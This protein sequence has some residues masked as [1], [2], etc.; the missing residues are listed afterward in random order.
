M[1][2]IFT[3][4]MKDFRLLLRDKAAFFFTLFF[5]FAIAVFFGSVFSVGS[6]DGY[7][8]MG[9]LAVDE[10]GTPGSAEFIRTLDTSAELRVEVTDRAEAERRVRQGQMPAY[11]VLK[12][13]FG[14]ARERPFWSGGPKVEMGMDPSRGA[15]AGMLEGILTTQTGCAPAFGM[16]CRPSR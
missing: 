12:R 3:L 2:I 9:I 13:G 14:E 10:D 7:Q 15:E 4:A 1:G 6:G 16:G 8:E 11:I 5:P